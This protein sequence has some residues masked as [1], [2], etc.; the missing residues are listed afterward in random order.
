M[1][2]SSDISDAFVSQFVADCRTILRCDPLDLIAVTL[3]ESGCRTTAHNP[4]GH[5]SGLWQLMPETARGLGW[6]ARD[7]DAGLPEF[8]ALDALGQWMWFRRYFRPHA[9]RLVNRAACYVATFLPADI[10]LAADP[11]AVLVERGGR[12][13]WAYEPNRGFDRRGD[14]RILVSDLTDAIDRAARGP[15]WDDLADRI[16]AEV[17]GLSP[18]PAP[19]PVPVGLDPIGSANHHAVADLVARYEPEGDE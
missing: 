4:N 8:R 12:R 7:C 9:G 16:V 5:A 2:P 10:A 6:N 3:N 11:S 18:L 1:G 19:P 13:G 15:R 17:H 14:G